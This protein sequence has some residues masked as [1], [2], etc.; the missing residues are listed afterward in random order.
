MIKLGFTSGERQAVAGISSLY[1]L[2][3]IGLFLL[4][5]V[6]SVYAS[7]LPNSTPLLIGL[8]LGIYGLAQALLQIPFGILSD[9]FGRKPLI[10][11]GLVLFALGSL[12][13]A[14][15]EHMAAL[16]LG[17]LLQGAGAISAVCIAMM[18]DLV[19][20]ERRSKAMACIGITIGLAFSVSLVLGPLLAVKLGLSGLFLILAALSGLAL[21]VLRY[22]I[23]SPGSPSASNQ[24]TS[25]Q[26]IWQVFQHWPIRSVAISIGLLHM[27]LA[28]MFMVVPLQ[29]IALTGQPLEQHVFYYLAGILLTFVIVFPLLGLV[30]RRRWHKSGIIIAITA[31]ALANLLLWQFASEVIVFFIALALFFL[32]FNFLEASF[33]ALMTRVAPTQNRGAAMGFYS[34]CQFFGIFLGGIVAGI[35][36]NYCSATTLYFILLCVTLCWLVM[37]NYKSTTE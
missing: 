9:K 8:A 7:K 35:V 37:Y 11:F 15:F 32:A 12:L 20:A 16:I 21:P 24:A 14:S 22:A 25:L 28:A 18:G 10:A 23:P 5:P 26:A 6:L 13:A 29:I 30:E 2:R 17:R 27:V 34:T 1:F 33:P 36:L 31:L 4:Y 3:I 19:A